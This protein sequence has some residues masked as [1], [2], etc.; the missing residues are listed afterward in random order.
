MKNMIQCVW[1]FCCLL[2]HQTAAQKVYADF[3]LF[4][5]TGVNEIPAKAKNKR[6]ITV[7]D[8]S[9]TEK[10]IRIKRYGRRQKFVPREIIWQAKQIDNYWLVVSKGRQHYT[11]DNMDSTVYINEKVITKR[12]CESEIRDEKYSLKVIEKID[13]G[14]RITLFWGLKDYKLKTALD[15]IGSITSFG[16]PLLGTKGKTVD[17]FSMS[18]SSLVWT[19]QHYDRNGMQ[20]RESKRV[21]ED[22]RSTLFWFHLAGIFSTDI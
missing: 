19:Y 1:V 6:T 7:F 5:F 3:D 20:V 8:K 16:F 10:E 22:F 13:S 21:I 2:G 12:V 14:I 15:S 11:C 17:E 9:S 4:S 18:G